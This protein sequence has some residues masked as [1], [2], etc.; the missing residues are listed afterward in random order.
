[1]V[2]F[3]KVFWGASTRRFLLLLSSGLGFSVF[4][5]VHPPGGDVGRAL[6]IGRSQG[7]GGG[8]GRSGAGGCSCGRLHRLVRQGCGLR[9]WL[10]GLQGRAGCR[11]SVFVRVSQGI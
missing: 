11:F 10:I 1:M 2:Q 9:H 4:F 3:L 8:G 5:R 7:S 6:H